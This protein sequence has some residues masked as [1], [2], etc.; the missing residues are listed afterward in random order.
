LE[1]FQLPPCQWFEWNSLTVAETADS[2]QDAILASRRFY[3]DSDGHPFEAG[4]SAFAR[5]ASLLRIEMTERAAQTG[6]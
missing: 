5:T 6:D 2:L 3:P 4:Y 1:G